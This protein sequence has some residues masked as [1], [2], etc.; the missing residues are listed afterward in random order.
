MSG[1]QVQSR[2]P[3]F[4]RQKM[5]GLPGLIVLS[6]VDD[7]PIHR[8]EFLGYFGESTIVTAVATDIDAQ[9]GRLYEIRHP[10]CLVAR[11]TSATHGG[12]IPYRS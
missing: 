7:S 12:L 2:L 11:K 4:I 1:F 5:N 9:T 3:H 6:V 10:Q 8:A